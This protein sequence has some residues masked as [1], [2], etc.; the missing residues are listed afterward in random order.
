MSHKF[1]F[2]HYASGFI[3]AL[4]H[5]DFTATWGCWK[6]SVLQTPVFVFISTF[7]GLE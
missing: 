2:G 4:H 7:A 6:Y 3:F 5:P 1:Y